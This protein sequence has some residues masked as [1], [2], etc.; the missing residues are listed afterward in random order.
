M[1][2]RHMTAIRLPGL[3]GGGIAEWD[4]VPVAEMIE[5]YRDYAERMKKD[6]EEVL[7]ASDADFRIETYRGPHAQRDRQIL[8]E[9][10]P[11]P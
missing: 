4:K 3:W 8:Q 9:G 7:S 10:R 5:R 6:A 11:K 2:G 1:S